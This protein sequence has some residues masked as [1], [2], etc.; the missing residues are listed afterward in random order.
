MYRI[1]EFVVKVGACVDDFFGKEVGM[2]SQV[3]AVFPVIG[4]AA[5]A[6]IS[7]QPPRRGC[8]PLRIHPCPANALRSSI[9]TDHVA[10][11]VQHYFAVALFERHSVKQDLAWHPLHDLDEALAVEFGYES[12]KY[13]ITQAISTI[14]NRAR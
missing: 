8:S 10:S 1:F 3:T 2:Y 9:V 6:G 4:R 13:C 7:I 12:E 5:G 11:S 14:S